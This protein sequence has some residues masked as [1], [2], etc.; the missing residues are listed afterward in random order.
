MQLNG[1]RH[2][3]VQ[4][5][6][7]ARRWGA[8][9]ADA[10]EARHKR[11]QIHCDHSRGHCSCGQWLTTGLGSW[12]KQMADVLILKFGRLL[13]HQ[14]YYMPFSRS[15]KLDKVAAETMLK[16]TKSTTCHSPDRASSTNPLPRQ[17]CRDKDNADVQAACNRELTHVK[18]SLPTGMARAEQDGHTLRAD[19]Q[20][21]RLK[22]SAITYNSTRMR[23]G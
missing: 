16:V 18:S 7:A 14:I 3:Q 2:R 9:N 15:L 13:D 1:S 17:C 12:S 8:R 10:N 21:S 6:V 4:Q 5:H 22:A 19:Q 20:T 23:S 11:R